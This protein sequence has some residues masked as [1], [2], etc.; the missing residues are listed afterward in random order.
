MGKG[1]GML[2]EYE[3]E[4]IFRCARDERNEMAVADYPLAGILAFSP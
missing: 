1:R 3:L 4:A 2:L